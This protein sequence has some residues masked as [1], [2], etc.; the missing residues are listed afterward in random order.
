M[1][2]LENTTMGKFFL[3]QLL[4]VDEM[5]FNIIIERTQVDK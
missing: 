4:D 1:G 5:E 2:L 3:N